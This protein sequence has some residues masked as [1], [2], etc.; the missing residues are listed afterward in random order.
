MV[1]KTLNILYLG[2]ILKYVSQEQIVCWADKYLLS[3]NQN[4]AEDLLIDLSLS[5][6]Y[7]ETVSIFERCKN[8]DSFFE[9]YL[10][11]YHVLNRDNLLS[12]NVLCT[13]M[14]V[15][16]RSYTD[17]FL[18]MS[19]TEI[20]EKYNF[21]FTRLIDHLGLVNDK[22]TS[23]MRMP[24]ELDEFLANYHEDIHLFKELGFRVCGIDVKNL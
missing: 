3:N 7:N 4:I 5:S 13:Q 24:D 21:F 17:V 9:Y 23:N 18:E 16:F 10:S 11:L 19:F 12:V 1:Q 14:I 2:Y 8:N 15:A 20:D 22:L 6:N